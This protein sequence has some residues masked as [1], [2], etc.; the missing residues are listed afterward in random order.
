MILDAVAL[1]VIHDVAMVTGQSWALGTRNYTWF[2]PDYLV[3]LA[4][5]VP[6]YELWMYNPPFT[7]NPI[8]WTCTLRYWAVGAGRHQFGRYCLETSAAVPMAIVLACLLALQLGLHIWAWIS[9]KNKTPL[10]ASDPPS[11]VE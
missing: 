4:S 3:D 5:R 10:F 1:V 6:D 8:M 9:S 7:F 2:N 11:D